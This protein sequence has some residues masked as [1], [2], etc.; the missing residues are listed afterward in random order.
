M[1]SDGYELRV[2]LDAPE[3]ALVFSDARGEL[4]RVELRDGEAAFAMPCRPA[5]CAPLALPFDGAEI[6][7]FIDRCSIEC[8][9][10]GGE[11]C[12]TCRVYPQDHIVACAASGPVRRVRAWALGDA[13]EEA[14]C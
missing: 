14:P 4:L 7:V 13:F 8:F 2:E 6:R 12:Y 11:A 9:V 3:G 5:V 1:Q 10:N